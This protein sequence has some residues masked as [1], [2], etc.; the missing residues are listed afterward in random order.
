MLLKLKQIGDV[1]SLDDL[2]AI[3][4]LLKQNNKPY[5]TIELTSETYNGDFGSYSLILDDDELLTVRNEG[6]T[7]EDITKSLVLMISNSFTD[8]N[9]NLTITAEKYIEEGVETEEDKIEHETT[10]RTLTY[11]SEKLNDDLSQIIIP[12]SDFIPSSEE[13]I[14][15]I[16]KIDALITLEFYPYVIDKKSGSLLYDVDVELI[17]TADQLEDV[18]RMAS[19]GRKTTIYLFPGKSFELSDTIEIKNKTI[20]LI[21]GSVP[22]ILDANHNCRHFF[23]DYD[24][25]LILKNITLTNGYDLD[26]NNYFGGGSIYVNS[27]IESYNYIQGKLECFDCNFNNNRS[28]SHGGA[29]YSN[30][31]LLTIDNCV[32]L[33]NT[34]Q[35][36]SNVYGN[37][38]AIYMNNLM[39]E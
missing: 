38:G 36:S 3:V 33:N 16:I 8:A 14:G 30:D 20:E 18:I 11:T 29:I 27:V 10:K 23:V 7:F 24:S 4:Y 34:A 17:E 39:E 22:A 21:S 31:A 13:N 37:G 35:S 2:N 15:E 12:L 6:Y 1:C 28:N 32:F 26:D 9:Y 5:E 25:K 19:T